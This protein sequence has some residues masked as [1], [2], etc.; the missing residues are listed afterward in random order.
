[1]A[2]KIA[3]NGFGRIGK[4]IFLQLIHNTNFQICCLNALDTTIDEIEDYLNYDSTHKYSKDIK[5][6]IISPTEFK[7]N[8]HIITLL[9]G[10]EAKNLNWKKYNA[11]DNQLSMKA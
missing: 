7:I 4:C 8:H 1:M 2:T 10:R 5:V 9:S 3:I 11:P 6:E